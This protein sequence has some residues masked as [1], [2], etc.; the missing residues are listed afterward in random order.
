M[1]AT[2]LTFDQVAG[3]RE[4]TR[5][6]GRGLVVIGGTSSY[7]PGGYAGTPLED[8]LPVTVKVT[9]GRERQRVALLMIMDKSGSM[10]Y[11]PLGGKGKIEMA[12]EAVRLAERA[13][14]EGDQVGLLVFNDR[15]EWVV[16]MTTI[17]DEST[18]QDIERKIEAIE[19][20]GGTEILPALSVGID[21]IRNA[22]ADARHVILSLMVSH[23]PE[24]EKAI[25]ACSTT[26]CPTG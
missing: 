18:R 10:G 2:A 16:P 1:P 22:E 11:D 4:V 21:A 12:K 15:Q 19:P 23:A 3:L 25:S 24:R 17:G 5:S 26:R 13:L 6:L 9:D 8:A 7:G 20:D 14:S